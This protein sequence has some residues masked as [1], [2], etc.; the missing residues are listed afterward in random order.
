MT[1]VSCHYSTKLCWKQ[2]ADTSIVFERAVRL[3]RYRVQ[4]CATF[5]CESS[6]SSTL[7]ERFISAI[8]GMLE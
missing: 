5:L 1:S 8:E 4:R 6:T 3:G 7:L 2:N